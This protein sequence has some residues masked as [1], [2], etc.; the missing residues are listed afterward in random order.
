MNDAIRRAIRTF[1]QGAVGTFALLA[2][3]ILNTIISNVGS[4][5]TV[6]LDPS[7]WR[8]IAIAVVAG[9]VIAF[10]SWLQNTLEAK[11]GVAP[12]KDKGDV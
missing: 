6:E 5:G 2:V 8:S 4:G 10:V 12:L 9:G 3:P 11:A 7:I 1:V